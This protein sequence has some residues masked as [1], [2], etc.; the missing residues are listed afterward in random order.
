ME[1]VADR[2]AGLV[3]IPDI[4]VVIEAAVETVFAR[5]TDR[6][7]PN[8]EF[9]WDSVTRDVTMIKDTVR[10]VRHV[11][12]YSEAGLQFILADVNGADVT[13]MVEEVA[14]LVELLVTCETGKN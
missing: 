13:S 6:N 3:N 11:Q 10:V 9:D 14:N 1:E 8:D 7:R 2:L 12:R 5:R 4:V